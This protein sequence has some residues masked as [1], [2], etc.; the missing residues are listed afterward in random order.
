MILWILRIV[1]RRGSAPPELRM[2]KR[3]YL[4]VQYYIAREFLF[5]FI[6]SFLFFF[7]IFFINQLLYMAEEI[8]SKKA[9]VFEVIKLVFFAMPAIIAM[10]FPFGSLVG[11]VMATGRLAS[12][13]ELLVMRASGIPRSAIFIPFMILGL[14]FSGISFVMNDYFLPLGTI[15]YLKIYRKLITSSP[16]LELKPYMVKRYQN[17]V[18]ITGDINDNRIQ[19]IVIFDKNED[20]MDRVI[21]AK[22]AVLVDQ[23][24]IQGIITLL[25]EDIFM[26]EF[27]PSKP[28]RFEY[29]NAIKM[30]YN[31]LLTKF[32][33]MSA[34]VGPNEMSSLDVKKIIGQKQALLNERKNVNVISIQDQNSDFSSQYISVSNLF[35]NIDNRKEIMSASFKKLILAN[36]KIIK[37]ITLDLYKLEYYKKFSIPF[38]AICF[39]FLSF[40]VG[41]RVKKNGRSVGFAFG[42]LVSVLY[43]AMLLG[44]QSLGVRIGFS[45]FLSI[46]APNLIVLLVGI[47][48]LLSGKGR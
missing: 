40:P 8:L 13:N 48:L 30:E 24:D 26:Q 45:P 4:T 34:S 17:T 44:G 46:W 39:I 2:K 15:N 19:D 38:G 31:I 37:D 1:E 41:I 23:G 43:W 3:N 18:I 5:S 11:S 25:M 20:G 27:N 42:L 10:S 36:S 32:T 16:A 35:T 47:P 21:T 28:D 33:N 29:T 9:P 6:V 22:S 7:I 14:V 12:D